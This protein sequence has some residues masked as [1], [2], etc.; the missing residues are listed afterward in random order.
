M[1]S[2]ISRPR[3]AIIVERVIVVS[4]R[5]MRS[6]VTI[7]LLVPSTWSSIASAP[8]KTCLDFLARIIFLALSEHAMF[9]LSGVDDDKCEAPIGT[10]PKDSCS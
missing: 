1:F 6:A 2:W 9:L 10:Y 4:V 7:Q 3:T 5:K 8:R